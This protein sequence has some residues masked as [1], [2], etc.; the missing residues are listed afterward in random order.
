M[1]RFVVFFVVLQS[2]LVFAQGEQVYARV[3][4]VQITVAQIQAAADAAGAETAAEVE[5]LAEELVSHELLLRAARQRGF[6][7]NVLVRDA[8]RTLMVQRFMRSEFDSRLTRESIP[9]EAVRARY[10]EDP[11]AQARGFEAAAEG[12]RGALWRERRDAAVAAL[13]DECR[14]R[15][16]V[17][18]RP[19]L[20]AQIPPQDDAP[21]TPEEQFLARFGC[22]HCARQLQ[23][24]PATPTNVFGS[25]VPSLPDWATR[26]RGGAD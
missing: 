1:S 4:D 15:T 5:A 12:I 9:I 23:D 10:G 20:L 11:A 6:E 21:S 7:E 17:N 22:A 25:P 19:E 14:E 8:W 26:S 13:L 16:P 24:N 2:S 18:F 3:G